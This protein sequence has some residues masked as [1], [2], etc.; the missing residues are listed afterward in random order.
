M[1]NNT[2]KLIVLEGIDGSGKSTQCKL[3]SERLSSDGQVFRGINFPRYSEPSSALIKMYLGGDFGH[4][5]KAVNA[6]AASTFFAVDRFSSYQLDWKAYYESGGVI[7]TDRYTTSN[8]IH[9]AAKLPVGDRRAFY[10]WLYEFEFKLLGLPEPSLVLYLNIP[11]SVASLR[12][13]QRE[14][15]RGTSADIHESDLRY[16]EECADCGDEASQ[17]YN[18]KKINCLHGDTP[19]TEAEIHKEIYETVKII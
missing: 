17:Y 9:Q 4:D 8:A 5:P 16:L 14:H 13:R 2:G 7:L 3:L 10:R 18:W 11:A 6:Y 12:L 19:R 15:E 1:K